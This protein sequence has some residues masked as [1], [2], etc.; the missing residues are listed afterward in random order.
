MGKKKPKRPLREKRLLAEV[1]KLVDA[2]T[3]DAPALRPAMYEGFTAFLQPEVLSEWLR[4]GPGQQALAL[5]ALKDACQGLLEKKT[6]DFCDGIASRV[7][8]V[9][10]PPDG[11]FGPVKRPNETCAMTAYLI[12]C[13]ACAGTDPVLQRSQFLEG[14]ARLQQE[15]GR[16]SLNQCAVIGDSVGATTR[17][18]QR[19]ALE[20][21]ERCGQTIWFDQDQLDRYGVTALSVAFVCR[22]CADRLRESGEIEPLPIAAFVPALNIPE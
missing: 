19:S 1:M 21:C 18:G 8:S 7:R 14:Y 12:L 4:V 9:F 20:S 10:I 5:L 11:D 22:K 16:V 17:L 13:D 15:A 6:C 3:E 2:T